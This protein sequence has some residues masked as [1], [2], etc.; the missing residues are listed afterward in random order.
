M[1]TKRSGTGEGWLWLHSS[2]THKFHLRNV[3]AANKS[4]SDELM[5]PTLT[6]K[7]NCVARAHT[8][9]LLHTVSEMK[10]GGKVTKV[11]EMKMCESE[12]DVGGGRRKYLPG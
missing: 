5:M 2:Q 7:L 8:H 11:K 12:G 4:K 1:T 9:S 10:G 6:N 3:A